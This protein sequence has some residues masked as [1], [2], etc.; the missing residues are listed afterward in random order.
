MSGRCSKC[1]KS[2]GG[3]FDSSCAQKCTNSGC[4]KMFC[5]TCCNLAGFIFK[6]YVCPDCGNETKTV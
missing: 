1:G 6:N 3:F 5:N 2:V 4:G